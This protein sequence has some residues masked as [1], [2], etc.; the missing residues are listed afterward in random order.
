MSNPVTPVVLSH[1]DPERARKLQ[2]WAANHKI[3]DLRIHSP[4][5]CPVITY[6][7][8]EAR[9]DHNSKE[10]AE[11]LYDFYKHKHEEELSFFPYLCVARLFSKD[12][13]GT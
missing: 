5:T 1:L 3:K 12:K 10:W 6:P 4:H 9:Y 7:L 8:A 2:I 11:W 13:C